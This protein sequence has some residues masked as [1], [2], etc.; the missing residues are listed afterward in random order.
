MNGGS[1]A[2]SFRRKSMVGLRARVIEAKIAHLLATGAP[3][4]AAALAAPP[5]PTPRRAP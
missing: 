1:A 2:G 3:P 4:Y 5:L